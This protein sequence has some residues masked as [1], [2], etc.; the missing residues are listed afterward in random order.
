MVKSFPKY[1]V[2]LHPV[3]VTPNNTWPMLVY[4]DVTEAESLIFDE[5]RASE[6]PMVSVF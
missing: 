5:E 6:S 2:S 1:V 4:T 3:L